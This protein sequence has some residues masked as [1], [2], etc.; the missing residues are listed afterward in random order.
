MAT[1]AGPAEPQPDEGRKESAPTTTSR[2]LDDAVQRV[3]EIQRAL[4]HGVLTVP[5]PDDVRAHLVACHA[6]FSAHCSNSALALELV[7]RLNAPELPW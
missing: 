1:N 4:D 3:R 7:A 5:Y 2:S 6:L